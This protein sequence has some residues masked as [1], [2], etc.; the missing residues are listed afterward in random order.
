[1][2]SKLSLKVACLCV[3]LAL[4][5]CSST[6]NLADFNPNYYPQCYDPIA[7]LCRDSDYGNE[8][9][10]TVS[11]ALIGAVLGALVGAATGK[12]ENAA[13]GA[14]VGAGVGAVGG[15]A[16]A[17][18]DKYQDQNQRL[19]QL[20]AML[21]EEYQTLDLEKSSVEAA[22]RCY[23]QEINKIKKAV[24]NKKMSKEEA[25][26]RMNEI[27]IG[28]YNLKQFWTEKSAT[29][30]AHIKDYDDFIVAESQ[31]NLQPYQR[32]ELAKASA[33]N[34][35]IQQ[36]TMRVSDNIDVAM[37]DLTQVTEAVIAS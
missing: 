15:F 13:I 23:A 26:S 37:S 18:I 9:R 36:E 5:G 8:L 32:S 33:R 6:K 31:R 4:T 35:F 20:H 1:M 11:G 12:S 22:L 28:M 17:K 34:H 30:D 27:K 3:A 29:V 16:K 10:D 21:G 7:K 2:Q 19:E 14:A 24:R 25:L